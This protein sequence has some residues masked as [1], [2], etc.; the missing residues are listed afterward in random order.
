M[1]RLILATVAFI[2]LAFAHA[3]VQA[4]LYPLH[5]RPPLPQ[6]P[7]EII[8]DINAMLEKLQQ[9][10]RIMVM[11]G[12]MPVKEVSPTPRRIERIEELPLP[13]TIP[14]GVAGLKIQ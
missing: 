7:E 8:D 5:P 12:M 10:D 6:T 14:S 13:K 4:V 3:T 9:E 11:P 2:F 1:N